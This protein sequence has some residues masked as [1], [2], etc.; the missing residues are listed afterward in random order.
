MSRFLTEKNDLD[1]EKTIS[2]VIMTDTLDEASDVLKQSGL[3]VSPAKLEVMVRLYR[4]RFDER[5]EELAPVIEARF[6]N[7]ELSNAMKA[8]ACI[9][10]AIDKTR[11]LLESGK[12]VD[13]ARVARDLSQVTAQAVDKR[14]AVQG[15][16]TQ[17]VEHRDPQ[18][19]VRALEAMKVATW[20][21]STAEELDAGG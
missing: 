7:R 5:R 11:E 6:A 2:A 21:D 3:T 9:D 13:P 20:V 16:P 19:I 12:C 14:L 15:R 17:I 1:M 4:E 18:E 10:I 8:A